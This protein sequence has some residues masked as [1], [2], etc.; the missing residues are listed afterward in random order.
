MVLGASDWQREHGCH[1]A[2]GN[3]HRRLTVPARSRTA[4][5]RTVRVIGLLGARHRRGLAEAHRADPP[6]SRLGHAVLER[7]FVIVGRW[8]HSD[9]ALDERTVRAQPPGR[10]IGGVLEG[11]KTAGSPG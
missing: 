4:S 2:C 8:C 3:R 1:C 7:G 10:V 9:D 5:S 11:G 6:A